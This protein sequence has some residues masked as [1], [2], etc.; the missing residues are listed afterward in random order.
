MAPGLPFAW[1]ATAAQQAKNAWQPKRQFLQL[2]WKGQ[3]TYHEKF[4][5]AK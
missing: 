5:T 1:P 2:S 4:S 3:Q